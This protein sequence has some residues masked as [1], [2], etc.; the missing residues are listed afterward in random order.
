MYPSPL[1][2]KGPYR[3]VLQAQFQ[4]EVSCCVEALGTH[5]L[6]FVHSLIVLGVG[7]YTQAIIVRSTKAAFVFVL[8]VI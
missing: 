3:L 4:V 6:T 1:Q 2:H 8:H 7:M 5:R